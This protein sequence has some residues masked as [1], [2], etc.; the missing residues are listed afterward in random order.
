MFSG[1]PGGKSSELIITWLAISF[2][3][4]FDADSA[5]LSQACWVPPSK[6]A[7]GSSVVLGGQGCDRKESVGLHG[8]S[9]RY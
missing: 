2:Q 9:P 7:R 1:L 8:W 5:R 3:R 4:A 6:D